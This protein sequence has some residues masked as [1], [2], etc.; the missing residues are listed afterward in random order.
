[1][2]P[3]EILDEHALHPGQAV[4]PACRFRRLSLAEQ[5]AFVAGNYRPSAT[6]MEV[7]ETPMGAL[8]EVVVGSM[9]YALCN[10]QNMSDDELPSRFLSRLGEGDPTLH[11]EFVMAW[12]MSPLIELIS[13][14]ENSPEALNHVI[15]VALP[16]STDRF[17]EAK[18]VAAS[19]VV[20]QS[21]QAVLN[22]LLGSDRR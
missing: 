20:K 9:D 19:I 8:A 7:V 4:L 14:M 12:E 18:H 11:A 13:L 5:K 1:M 22:E 15:D 21:A 3:A 10:G 16:Y 2:L 17:A 6:D